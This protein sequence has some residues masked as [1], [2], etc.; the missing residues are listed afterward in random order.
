MIYLCILVS[1]LL[2]PSITVA[3]LTGS[4]SVEASV[5]SDAKPVAEAIIHR[6]S[7]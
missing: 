5:G 6:V 2:V 3:E 7:G 4:S 1:Y